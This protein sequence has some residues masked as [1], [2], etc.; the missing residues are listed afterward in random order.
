MKKFFSLIILSMLVVGNMF[1]ISPTECD[2]VVQVEPCNVQMYA[3]SDYNYIIV[4]VSAYVGKDKK[5]AD[6]TLKREMYLV[7]S[8]KGMKPHI[9]VWDI[10]SEVTITPITDYKI[11]N[12]NIQIELGKNVQKYNSSDSVTNINNASVTMSDYSEF[13]I[14]LSDEEKISYDMDN[15]VLVA[16]TTN[17]YKF[18]YGKEKTYV[19][20]D[21]S[22]SGGRATSPGSSCNDEAYGIKP[23]N[24]EYNK[25]VHFSHMTRVY[26][27]GTFEPGY[28]SICL[29]GLNIKGKMLK[30]DFDIDAN[31]GPRIYLENFFDIGN[32]NTYTGSIEGLND[33]SDY[34][35]DLKKR[36]SFD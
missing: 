16:G 23:N 25:S 28:S 36:S 14:E 22:I 12:V 11:K 34:Y 29:Y 21:N 1:F 27:K 20:E 18:K 33:K 8:S 2:N 19:F 30:P 5:V 24:D 31:K 7:D 35:G 13:T 32:N 17:K 4:Q 3:N 15:A 6:I 9:A 26:M 10:K